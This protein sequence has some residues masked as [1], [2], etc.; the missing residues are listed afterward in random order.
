MIKRFVVSLEIGFIIL[1]F[2][3]CTPSEKFLRTKSSLN[4]QGVNQV[5]V[6]IKV[7]SGSFKISSE[8]G[9]RV[10][11]KETSKILYK[12]GNGGLVFHPEKIKKI[13]QLESDKN[14]LFLNE[15]GYRGKIELHNVLGKIYIINILNIEEYL[16]SV[17]PSEMPSLWNVEALKAQ[18]VASRTYTYYHLL[19]NKSKSIYDLDSTTNFQVYKGISSEKDSSTEAVNSTAGI[20][21]TYHYEPIIAYFHSTSGGKTSDDKDVWSGTDLPYLESVDCTY[22]KDSPHYQWETVLTSEEIK[23]ALSKKYKRIE[24]I[25]KMSFKKNNDRVIEVNVIHNNG[26]LTLSGNEF[27]L[28]FTPQKLKS[29]FFTA[30]ME[31]GSLKISGKGWGHGV[32]MCQWGAKG[33]SEKGIKYNDILSYYYKGIK[34]QKINNNYVAHK[35]GSSKLVN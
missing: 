22:S 13:Y 4:N 2:I 34:F 30:K 25:Q 29:T 28:L 16:Y 12:T 19:K 1:F 6:L 21:M 7:L 3:T 24:K 18:S 10:V 15:S 23:S 33:R 17:V 9:V 5:R 35:K 11:D 27:R 20:I 26:T 31:K 14:I 32:G 8:S